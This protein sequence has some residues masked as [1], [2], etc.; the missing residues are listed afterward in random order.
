MKSMTENP[1]KSPTIDETKKQPFQLGR[2]QRIALLMI[3]GGGLIGRA[4]MAIG[5]RDWSPLGLVV[6]T[7][8]LVFAVGMVT[9]RIKGREASE[10]SRNAQ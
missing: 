10:G 5:Q 6:V 4:D 9:V 7:G 1:Y 8:L 2:L 3:C